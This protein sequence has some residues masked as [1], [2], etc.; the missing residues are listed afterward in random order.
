MSDL[1]AD[2][3]A[4]VD[5]AAAPV[6]PGEVAERVPRAGGPSRPAPP[7]TEVAAPTGGCGVPRRGGRRHGG[8]RGGDHR[9]TGTPPPGHP[10]GHDAGGT[11]AADRLAV[12]RGVPS[13]PPGIRARSPR[14]A[15]V[16]PRPASCP[17]TTA[18]A[19][20]RR[21]PVRRTCPT[22]PDTT[23]RRRRCRPAWPRRRP[24]RAST[25]SW[26]SAGGGLLDPKSG[27]PLAKKELRDPVLLTTTDA[28][29]TWQMHKVPIP[30]AIEYIPAYQQFPAETTYWPGVLD[31]VDCTSA[32]VCDVVG[33]VLDATS[34]AAF[35]PDRLEFL[36]TTDGG[37][38]WTRTV[39][40][41]GPRSRASRSTVG[42]SAPAPHWPARR[43]PL[44][45]ARRTVAPRPAD[46]VVDG[47]PR[48]TAVDSGTRHWSRGRT[49]SSRAFLPRH[50]RCAGAARPAVRSC[51]RST[52]GSTGNWC[53]RH[54]P[55]R[56]GPRPDVPATGTPGGSGSI[57]QSSAVTSARP[58]SWAAPG[59]S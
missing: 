47:W 30:P 41:S 11:M 21:S 54:R 33:H 44:C 55:R 7:V 32:D 35:T 39:L 20:R 48:V 14:S 46:G 12:R 37:V 15:A 5:A 27:D 4:L 49:S 29:A 23:G 10:D 31:A 9:P 1:D 53:R 6:T 24:S 52:V 28:G 13:S 17:P 45:G 43:H 59:W 51:D 25:A 22:T 18:W 58:A 57:W 8:H 19:V 56:P 40:P 36:R 16:D 3:R 50:P 2:L 34:S 38:T 42:S 26:C